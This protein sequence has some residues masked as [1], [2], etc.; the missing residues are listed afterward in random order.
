MINIRLC[1]LSS[2]KEEFDGAKEIYQ[3]ALQRSGYTEVLAYKEV[4][5]NQLKARAKEVSIQS[6]LES[7]FTY[8][9]TNT[10]ATILDFVIR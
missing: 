2:C 9:K 8:V 5:N 7:R 1:D 10:W 3:D 6:R 4:A